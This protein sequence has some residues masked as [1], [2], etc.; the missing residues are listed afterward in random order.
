MNCI[1]NRLQWHIANGCIKQLV[2]DGIGLRAI[3]W[4]FMGKNKLERE[5]WSDFSLWSKEIY[6]LLA[7][8]LWRTIARQYQFRLDNH[9][10]SICSRINGHY[11]LHIE[12]LFSFIY[13]SIDSIIRRTHQCY[14]H[15]FNSLSK[16][17]FWVEIII[18]RRCFFYRQH[19]ARLCTGK[20]WWDAV[21]MWQIWHVNKALSSTLIIVMFSVIEKVKY[22]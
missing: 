19:L 17:L 5:W 2:T 6:Y 16:V 8:I 9:R 1:F 13:L 18:P 11:I 15:Q 14:H 7:I 12:C 10:K 4:T 22:R 21:L 3:I 20:W